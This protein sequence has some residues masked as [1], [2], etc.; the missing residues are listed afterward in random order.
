MP[1]TIR[2]EKNLRFFAVSIYYIGGFL[3]M[4]WLT[5]FRTDLHRLPLP[6]EEKIP[7]LPA[8]ILAYLLVYVFI[9][10]AYLAVDDLDFFKK[11]VR[12]MAICVTIHFVFFLLY[13]VHYS[14]RPAVDPDQGWAYLLVDYYYFIDYPYNAFPSMHVSNAFLVSFMINRFRRGWGWV[15]HPAAVLLAVSVVLVKQHYIVDVLAGF[16]VGWFCYW[17]VFKR[18]NPIPPDPLHG[19]SDRP[20]RILPARNVNISQPF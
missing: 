18:G 2:L 5:S 16:L 12:A 11:M 20:S 1:L 10:L 8:F 9:A 6:G 17:V 13:P 15:L 4:N 14:L 19:L 3:P 7:F